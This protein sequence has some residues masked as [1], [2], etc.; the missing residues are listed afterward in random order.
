MTES[1]TSVSVEKPEWAKRFLGV[2][3]DLCPWCGGDQVYYGRCTFST[4]YRCAS[5][6]RAWFVEA[7]K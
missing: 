6:D 7:V 2:S 5:C 3:G 1:D 4:H